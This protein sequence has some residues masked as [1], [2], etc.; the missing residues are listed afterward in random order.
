[1]SMEIS[2]LESGK[3]IRRK[4]K[5]LTWMRVGIYITLDG[6]KYEGNWSKN[7]KN[8][9]GNF[10]SNRIGTLIYANNEKYEGE[11]KNDKRD[12]NGI[13]YYENGDKYEGQYISGKKS[14]QG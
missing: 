6:I 13:F 14:G 7:K 12:G 2:I 4:E 5:V 3:T 1:M 10:M 9:K 8:G 11:W